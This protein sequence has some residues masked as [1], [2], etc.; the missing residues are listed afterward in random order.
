MELIVE[1]VLSRGPLWKKTHFVE[2][3]SSG[4]IIPGQTGQPLCQELGINL[5][6]P[7]AKLEYRPTGPGHAPLLTLAAC[8]PGW[9][10]YLDLNETLAEMAQ[11]LMEEDAQQ[12]EAVPKGG[13]INKEKDTAKIVVLPLNDDTTFVPDSEFPSTQYGLGTCENPV[14]LSDAPTEASNTGTRP[15]GMDPVD[16][17]KILGHFSDALNE[18]A[19][20]ILDLEDSYFRALREVIIEMEKAL[21]D[22][23]HIDT[24]YVSCIVTVM[25]SWQEAVQAAVSHME[26]A[27]LT[28]YLAHWEDAQRAMKE[29][30][31]KVIM[32]CKEHDA[33]HTKET[34]ARKEA[35]K[36]GDPEDPVI[37]L[38][39]VM[40]KAA[41]AQAERVVDAFLNKIQETL[42]KHV[43]VSAQGPLIANALS[44][45]FQFQMSVWQMIG[46]E[47]VH[48]LQAKHS[49]WCGLAGIIQAIVETFPKNCAIMFPPALAPVASFS[50]TFKPPSSEEDNVNNSFSPGLSRFDSGSPAPSGSGRSSFS[51]SP[52]FSSTSL[53]QGGH[54][55]LATDQK[56]APSSSLSTPPLGSEEPETQHL[57]EDLDVGLEAWTRAMERRTSM[58]ATISMLRSSRYYKS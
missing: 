56:E 35:I 51:C 2:R 46:D 36:T 55:F 50:T 31:A 15:E 58:V 41:H 7:G 4:E 30:V 39:D 43:P 28:I 34:E 18:M 54:L 25:A 47:C 10:D 23:S 16:E 57:D 13:T 38:L 45:A 9:D 22:I 21:Q 42:Q 37:C 27:D 5:G 20:S 1:S 40:H 6:A 49:D 8:H 19:K 11:C 44:T 33:A 32:A 29:Y 17:S 26:N 3:N 48:P 12:G 24:H 53:L 14:N 52:A